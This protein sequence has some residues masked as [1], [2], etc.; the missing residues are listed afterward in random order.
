MASKPQLKT[1]PKGHEFFKS[2]DCPVCPICE[3]EKKPEDVYLAKIGAPARRAIERAGITQL[4]QFSKY[5]EKELLDMHGFGP[6]AIMILK[7]FLEE[8]G[9]DFRKEN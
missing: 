8:N 6:K 5:T 7:P 1:C 4:K 3:K 9:L 2:S